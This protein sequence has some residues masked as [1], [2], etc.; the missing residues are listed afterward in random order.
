[1]RT[2]SRTFAKYLVSLVLLLFAWGLFAEIL[3]RP[4]ALP[5]PRQSL[6]ALL[7]F[8]P[9]LI[10]GAIKTITSAAIGGSLGIGLGILIAL[11]LARS[12][13]VRQTC[14][15]YLTIF[16]SFPREVLAPL[17]V[18]LVGFELTH[19]SLAVLLPLFPVAIYALNGL[20]DTP[21]EYV[22]L[23]RGWGATELQILLRCRLPASV[24]ALIGGIKVGLPL[25]LIGSVLAE[26]VGGSSGLGF[27][28]VNN[29]NANLPLSF[30]AVI[31]L[32]IVGLAVTLL[33]QALEYL[34]FDRFYQAAERS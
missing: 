18:S 4:Y 20:R 29:Q 34:A 11:L 2:V 27:I 7:H 13:W 8:W 10:H 23:M 16:Q 32:A 22:D 12:R 15:P 6:G 5:T 19:I 17:L 14:E 26:L 31:V 21:Q 33:S 3:N 30:A 1:M 24:P 28:I 9:T 25:A